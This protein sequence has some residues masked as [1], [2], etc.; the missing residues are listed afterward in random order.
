LPNEPAKGR[1]LAALTL[2]R[3]LKPAT[4]RARR[5]DVQLV[6]HFD[7]AC[8]M[9]G[10]LRRAESL[11][12]IERFSRLLVRG[13]PGHPIAFSI[14]SAARIRPAATKPLRIVKPI[15]AGLFTSTLCKSC[16][17]SH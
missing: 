15:L 17:Q 8:V 13:K 7:G 9:L 11:S 10:I 3:I 4:Q 6:V 2:G 16:Y 14:A 12:K 1:D 5:A